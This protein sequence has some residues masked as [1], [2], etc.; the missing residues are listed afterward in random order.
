MNERG[1]TAATTETDGTEETNGRGDERFDPAT[2]EGI[3]AEMSV[4]S[5]LAL[6]ALVGVFAVLAGPVG[7][8]GGLATAIVWYA[9]GTPY[10]VALG[11]VALVALFPEE[12]DRVSFV[13]AEASFVVLLLTTVPQAAS[14]ARIRH[15]VA[16][17]GST[18]VLGAAVWIVLIPAGQ[19]LW[20]AA[21]ALLATMACGVYGL[22]RYERIIVRE[23]I[24]HP[25]DEQRQ[26]RKPDDSG[27]E[28]DAPDR[29][30]TDASASTTTEPLPSEEHTAQ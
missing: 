21:I 16:A 24:S 19:P 22:Y 11:H 14:G 7:A 17:L 15:A 20:I 27:P 10:G 26:G 2:N 4:A 5:L 28:T 6:A 23:A 1:T 18:L 12:I 3:N 9:I 30:T 13:V 25:T 29:P 8:A